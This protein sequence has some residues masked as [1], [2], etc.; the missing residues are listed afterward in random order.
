MPSLRS[1]SMPTTPLVRG[2]YGAS[3][4]IE[5]R[6]NTARVLELADVIPVRLSR[7]TFASA[8]RVARTANQL[9][10]EHN[11][12]ISNKVNDVKLKGSV[13]VEPGASPW[14][15]RVVT[16]APQAATQE[17]GTVAHIITPSQA[18]LLN[19][20]W[21]GAGVWFSGPIVMHPGN[22]PQPFLA[23]ARAREV[24]RF[25]AELRRVFTEFGREWRAMP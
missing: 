2:G 11:D 14:Q 20:Y 15:W 3:I 8:E 25:T 10:P 23:P 17:Y 5:G 6:R 19:F 21:K 18:N 1:Q 24:P 22:L 16:R 9:A 13:V 7:M 12:D 4:A